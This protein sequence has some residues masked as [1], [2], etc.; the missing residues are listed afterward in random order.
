MYGRTVCRQRVVYICQFSVPYIL[1]TQVSDLG[2]T[3]ENIA[4]KS[5]EYFRMSREMSKLD[6]IK[7]LLQKTQSHEQNYKNSV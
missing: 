6:V 7:T 3:A 1:Y 4:K 2:S 5:F